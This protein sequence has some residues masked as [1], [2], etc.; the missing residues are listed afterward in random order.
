MHIA[1]G[2]TENIPYRPEIDG[3]RAIAVIAAII[4]HI[5]ERWIPGGFVGVDIF[6]VISGYLLTSIMITNRVNGNFTFRE[7]YKRRILR[8]LPLLFIVLTVTFTIFYFIL[9]PQDYKLFNY[10]L[11]ATITFLSNHFFALQTDYFSP[12]LHE[13]PLLHTWSLSIEEQF[14]FL[15]PII[16]VAISAISGLA[17][18]VSAIAVLL[19]LSLYLSYYF[20]YVLGEQIQVF[21]FLPFRFSELL[22][23]CLIAYLPRDS[24]KKKWPLTLIGS[25]LLIYPLVFFHKT[26][27]FPGPAAMIPCLGTALIIIGAKKNDI[28][29]RILSTPPLVLIGLMSYS[30]YLW[31][32]PVLVFIRYVTGWYE[33]RGLQLFSALILVVL[34]SLI[35]WTRIEN[36]LRRLPYSFTRALMVFYVLPSLVLLSLSM[37]LTREVRPEDKQLSTAGG[38]EICNGN[39]TNLARCMKGKGGTQKVLVVGD[40]HSAHLNHFIQKLGELRGW[41]ATVMSASS[42]SP[43]INYELSQFVHK[44]IRTGC[45]ELINTFYKVVPDFQTVI[46][47]TRWDSQ[48][49]LVA[50]ETSDPDYLEKFERTLK[51]LKD[52]NKMVFVFS[53]LPVVNLNYQKIEHFRNIGLDHTIRADDKPDKA[54]AI[55]QKIVLKFNNVR[56]VNFGKVLDPVEKNFYMNGKPV[57]RD[58][59]HFNKWGAI[60]TANKVH[61]E[62]LFPELNFQ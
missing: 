23:G 45:K 25:A 15:W 54:N 8:I 7:F 19:I 47:V 16:F 44:K 1:H 27:I 10:T 12:S 52:L 26:M 39:F 24:F 9:A 51:H 36:P 32:Y 57:Y 43:V 2:H 13:A 14:Y 55:I 46:F 62:G 61:Q 17:K 49:G 28:I 59:N 50:G 11:R 37:I 56:W 40:S 20:L 6:F 35:T 5:D 33:V 22:I 34:L 38:L 21:F 48:L 30:L 41:S 18:K 60:Q 4:F 31:H 58:T 53:Q 42:C 29:T 3:L